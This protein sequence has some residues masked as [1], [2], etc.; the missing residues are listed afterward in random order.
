MMVAVDD[1]SPLSQREEEK[2]GGDS[3][4]RGD[5]GEIT[6]EL[7]QHNKSS[8]VKHTKNMALGSEDGSAWNWFYSCFGCKRRN[9]TNFERISL[10]EKQGFVVNKMAD[11]RG[12]GREPTSPRNNF[13]G[14]DQN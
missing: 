14:R 6:I 7:Y 5:D 13:T 9:G 8:G 3:M 12:V 2:E 11:S 10:G 1:S 4:D